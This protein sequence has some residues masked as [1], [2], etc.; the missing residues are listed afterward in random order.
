[1]SVISVY[2]VS[3]QYLRPTFSVSGWGLG[4]GW[5]MDQSGVEGR[6]E[7]QKRES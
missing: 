3:F 6:W 4:K 5:D 7:G 2:K 1:M